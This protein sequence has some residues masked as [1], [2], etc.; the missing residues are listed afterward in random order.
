MINLS[1]RLKCIASMVDEGSIL[2]DV[3][4][5]HALL[6]IFLLQN[7]II[8]KAIAC[9]IT[10]GALDQARKNVKLYNVK[11]IDIRLSDGFDK[12]NKEDNIN[13][14]VMSGLGD[15]KIINILKKGKS[16]LAD[17]DTMII[18]SNVGVEKIRRYLTKNGYFIHNEIL[19]KEK[20]IIYTIIKFKK[21]YVKYSKKELKY[22]PILLERKDELFNELLNNII[23]SNEKI[24]KKI[25]R[26][27]TLKIIKLI[28]TNKKIKRILK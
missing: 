24:I 25:P 16:K 13:L 1:K 28:I 12:I 27:K 3:G 20:D 9:D 6:D 4:C 22:G 18:Q 8:R 19:I 21:G 26:S 15:T 14:I 11:N 23:K 7:N 5:D 2:A 17:V 10:N